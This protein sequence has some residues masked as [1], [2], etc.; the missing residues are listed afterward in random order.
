MVDAAQRGVAAHLATLALASTD[1]NADADAN[2]DTDAAVCRFKTRVA[3]VNRLVSG[4]CR[5][6]RPTRRLIEARFDLEAL[7][8]HLAA[9]HRLVAT[10][11][12]PLESLAA[13]VQERSQNDADESA[14][15]PSELDEC[16]ATLAIR[17]VDTD[18]DTEAEA[19]VDAEVEAGGEAVTEVEVDADAEAEEVAKDDDEAEA[20]VEDED[21]PGLAEAEA[22]VEVE[23]ARS[24]ARSWF[25]RWSPSQE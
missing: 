19:D 9:A 15:T 16:I 7:D 4:L 22:E 5:E 17:D 1:A 10:F 11:R 8:A 2:A 14:L 24:P 20:E 13:A 18:T 25:R 23:R 6:A 21:W 3:T 12:G